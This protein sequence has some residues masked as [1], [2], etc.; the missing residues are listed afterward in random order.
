MDASELELRA[1]A[2]AVSHSR[3][4]VFAAPLGFGQDGRVWRTNHTTVV[5]VIERLTTYNREKGCYQRLLKHDV[6]EINGLA[7]PE[8]IDFDDE[9]QIIEIGMVKPPYLLDFGKA[10]LDKPPDY[11]AESLDDWE[12]EL[13][14]LFGE[15]VSQVKLVMWQLEKFGIYYRDAK[16]A[17]I[18]LRAGDV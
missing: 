6:N 3:E 14:E 17:N 5:K 7:V 16:P 12:E 15:D 13:V 11:T 10:F 1:K 4:I 2:Y 8:F 18:R 9:L